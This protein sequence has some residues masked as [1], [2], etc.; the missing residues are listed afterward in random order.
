MMK[1]LQFDIPS[2]R[3]AYAD[4]LSPEAVVAEVFRRIDE[5]GDTGIFISTQEL[6]V[7]F[8]RFYRVH[9]SRSRRS[10]GSGLGLAIAQVIAQAHGEK[11]R[12][13]SQLGQGSIFSVRL[14][15]KVV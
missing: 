9:E 14:P 15:L 12:V 10:G 13:Q 11:I 5:V 8:D 3:A 6:Q 2:L 1:Q 4:G 7:I